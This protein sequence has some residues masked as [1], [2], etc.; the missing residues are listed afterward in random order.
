MA[1]D[2]IGYDALAREALRGV[3][4]DALRIAAEDGLPGSHHF[5]ITF[6]TQAE[7]VDLDPKLIDR[8]PEEMTI[9]LEH[10]FWDLTVDDDAFEVTLEFNR[11][12]K[13]LRVPFAAIVQFHDPSVSFGLRFDAPGDDKPSLPAP[14]AVDGDTDGAAPQGEAG[15]EKVVSLDAFRKKPTSS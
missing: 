12:P 2:Q 3:V 13:Y 4:R 9:V 1:Q 6:R 10:R 15:A 7:D 8:F 14:D 5:Y 11:A